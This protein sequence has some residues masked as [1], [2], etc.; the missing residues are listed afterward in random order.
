MEIKINTEINKILSQ[1]FLNL[2]KTELMRL[3]EFETIYRVLEHK[4]ISG[5]DNI[6][7]LFELRDLCNQYNYDPLVQ[8]IEKD[9]NIFIKENRENI[10]V[11]NTI[12]RLKDPIYNYI[13]ESLINY[14]NTL[15]DF[16]D[17]KDIIDV[18]RKEMLNSLNI[19][20]VPR[21][22]YESLKSYDNSLN[23]YNS[24]VGYSVYPIYSIVE[25]L[26]PD[27]Y[28]FYLDGKIAHYKYGKINLFEGYSNKEFIEANEYLKNFEINQNSLSLNLGN[29]V[30]EFRLGKNNK[31][32]FLIDGKVVDI[33][34]YKFIVENLTL[35][36]RQLSSSDLK[37]IRYIYENLDFVFEI[38]YGKKIVSK[39]SND[40]PEYKVG[41][42]FETKGKYTFILNESNGEYRIFRNLDSLE[43]VSKVKNNLN[44]DLSKDINFSKERREL[45]LLKE[46]LSSLIE[47]IKI[48]REKIDKVDEVL[49]KDIKIEKREKMKMLKNI[50]EEQLNIRMKKYKA[51]LEKIERYEVLLEGEEFELVIDTYKKKKEDK[52]VILGKGI[53]GVPLGTEEN[54]ESR[55]INIG[56]RVKVSTGEVGTVVSKNE[57]NGTFFVVMDDGKGKD[58]KF[59]EVT[60]IEDEITD[61]AQ[62]Y[63]EEEPGVE[64]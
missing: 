40:S 21:E 51:L 19:P 5:T 45:E 64:F 20:L 28:F 24:G 29:H 38:D 4:F 46:K 35:F 39:V 8:K 32:E 42:V 43:L 34:G 11:L 31:K 14:S 37:N 55:E 47:E 59:D 53:G 2:S 1:S 63:L 41:Y 18:S 58:V 30:V 10:D 56:D 54:I 9:I 22:V 27:E 62:K 48:I 7:V 6:S 44:V 26:N 57:V 61:L 17:K 3:E 23:I 50:L 12:N 49:L 25:F 60:L 15:F 36:S 33:D 52:P 16:R 13:R